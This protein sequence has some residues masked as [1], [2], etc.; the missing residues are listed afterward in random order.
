MARNIKKGRTIVRGTVMNTIKK[1]CKTIAL[2]LIA[3]VMLTGC[4]TDVSVFDNYDAT[5][6]KEEQN[7]VFGAK[8]QQ[9]LS[10]DICVVQKKKQ[11]KKDSFMT[12]GAS[13]IFDNTDNKMLYADN[14]YQKMYPASTTKIV[15][16]LVALKYGNLDDVVTIGYNATHIAEYGAKLCGFAEGDKITLK[17]LLYS[18]LICSGND[19]GIAIAEHIS[20]S[21]EKFAELMN[22]EAKSLGCSGS[23]FVNP[24]GL[25]D[26]DHYTTPYDLYLVFHEL[27]NYDVFMDIINHSSYKAEFN[28]A[29][30]SKKTLWFASTD[31]YLLGSA[32]A[33]DGV[34]V[35][36]GKTGTTSM[37]GSNLILYTKN[38]NGK[39]YISVVMHASDSFN[40]YSQMSHLLEME[41][42]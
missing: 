38:N 27:L 40:L 4:E 24:H 31:K 36:G 3:S 15:T 16:A 33:P 5:L 25:H 39:S 29:D 23:N 32:K 11:S 2:V 6:P 7:N 8:E 42:K 20:G 26:D 22:K 18:F 9:L 13:L 19:A 12:A 41:N 28:G 30:G 17:K 21:V 34:T 35:I 14:I 1:R 37:A 10:S